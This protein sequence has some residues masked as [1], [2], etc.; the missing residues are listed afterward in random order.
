MKILFLFITTALS[1]SLYTGDCW[2]NGECLGTLSIP[3]YNENLPT[4]PVSCVDANLVECGGSGYF[5]CTGLESDASTVVNFCCNDE[6]WLY[7]EENSGIYYPVN[8]N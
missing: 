3:P 2:L 5:C 1:Q 7:E 6:Q 8:V 4:L